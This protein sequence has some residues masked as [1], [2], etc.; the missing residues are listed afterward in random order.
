VTLVFREFDQAALDRQYNNQANVD[1]PRRYL[2]W[3]APASEAAR[4]RV[5]HLADVAY[6]HLPE[7]KLDIFMP[8]GHSRSDRRPVVAFLHGGAWRALG[9]K[10]SSFPAATFTERGAL[11]V[12]IGF[13][14]M[15]AAG[16]LDEMVWQCRTALAWLATEIAGHGGD[17]ER[18][19]LI[20]HSSGGHLAGMVVS[21]DWARHFSIIK[22]VVRAAVL[23][24]GLYDLEP[25]RLSYRN[26]MLKLDRAAEI[27]NSPCRNLPKRGPPLL[28]VHGEHETAE[29]RRQAQD[30]A[31]LWKRRHGN[32][33]S[34]ELAGLNHYETIESLTDPASTLSQRTLGWF[35]I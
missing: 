32:C 14:L 16:S 6:G 20:G 7:Q 4:A 18:I 27:R 24:S 30:Y 9:L 31:A 1:D 23:V 29:F 25:V 21:T 28:V 2:D 22:P 35:G 13:A 11:Y 26:E 17:P 12:A 5:A 34:I 15:P 33:E 10:G 3:Y 19:Y 8:P